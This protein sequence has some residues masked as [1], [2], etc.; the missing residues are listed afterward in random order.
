MKI[1][2]RGATLAGV[3]HH[4][5][6]VNNSELHVVMAGED[7]P[8]ILLVHGFP[9]TWWT[10]R[11]LIPRLATHHR[12]VAVDLRGFGDS[13]PADDCFDSRV[14]A[15]DLRSLIETLAI[16]PVHLVGQDISGST[17]VRLA[18]DAPELVA[19][20]TAIEMGLAG[21][22]LETFADPAKGGAWHIGALAAPGVASVFLRG[23]ERA[24]IADFMIRPMSA[25]PDALTDADVAEFART[26][27]RPNGWSGASALYRS[28]LAE[29]E[30]IRAVAAAGGVAAPVLAIGTSGGEFTARTMEHVA[31]GPVTS[32]V[33]E[34]VGHYAALEAPEAVAAAIAG[35]IE[36]LGHPSRLRSQDGQFPQ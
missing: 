9:E 28:M 23:R 26:Y 32:R 14:A 8:P 36:T 4:L 27:E 22:G 33:L 13:A 24:F 15:T 12:V 3:S 10:F 30:D 25:R 20:L 7:G 1:D 16:G 11:G 18:A 35:F 34:N 29:G 31:R 17:V 5:I 2:A 19:S 21:F 6:P